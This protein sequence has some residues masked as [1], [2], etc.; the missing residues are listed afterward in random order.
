MNRHS[1]T[2]KNLRLQHI[3]TRRILTK[4]TNNQFS[5]MVISEYDLDEIIPTTTTKTHYFPKQM[6]YNFLPHIYEILRRNT[7][8]NK[9]IFSFS[10][11]QSIQEDNYEILE[12][13]NQIEASDPSITIDILFEKIK[14]II[15]NMPE[16]VYPIQQIEWKADFR[17][18]FTKYEIFR[19]DD[20][21][22]NKEKI[23][24]TN[25]CIICFEAKPN[26]LFCNCD[27]QVICENCWISLNDKKILLY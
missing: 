15:D 7:H 10:V 9:C 3:L 12:K 13:D 23:F 6:Y 8:Q 26:V 20:N 21:I 17:L 16:L 1:I 4:N 11:Y 24:I 27:H 14:L 22:T 18:V 2:S 5:E 25:S 19:P